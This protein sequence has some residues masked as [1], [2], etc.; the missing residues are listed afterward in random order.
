MP[1]GKESWPRTAPAIQTREKTIP[2]VTSVERIGR[3]RGREEGIL[4]NAR[5]AVMDILEV[6]FEQ[7]PKF[8]ENQIQEIED[9]NR[10]KSLLRQAIQVAS[11][12]EFESLLSPP[13]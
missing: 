8:L 1:G 3:Q 13:G 10:L 12:E 2:Y 5:E 9:P 11:L 4:E 6:R 7:V